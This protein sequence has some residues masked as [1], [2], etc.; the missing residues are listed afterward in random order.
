[1]HKNLR[2][3]TLEE[4][5][6]LTAHLSM[7]DILQQYELKIAGLIVLERFK[8]E[9][10]DALREHSVDYYVPP[11]FFVPKFQSISSEEEKALL[12]E[13]IYALGD[14][15][16]IQ[17]YYDENDKR[18]E[19]RREPCMILIRETGI[20]ETPGDLETKMLVFDPADR[21]GSFERIYSEL[22]RLNADGHALVVQ[23]G[24]GFYEEVNTK[25]YEVRIAEIPISLDD[26]DLKRIL[27][28]IL[29]YGT[30]VFDAKIHHV[31][32]CQLNEFQIDL[33]HGFLDKAGYTLE[34]LEK[35]RAKFESSLPAFRQYL[36]KVISDALPEA[37]EDYNQHSDM[38]R[39]DTRFVREYLPFKEIYKDLELHINHKYKKMD[40]RPVIGARNVSMVARSHDHFQYGNGSV[41]ICGGLAT[42]LVRDNQGNIV[43]LYF[44]KQSDGDHNY[45]RPDFNPTYR[46]SSCAAVYTAK[47]D[48]NEIDLFDL[49]TGRVIRISSENILHSE[50]Y[51][52]TWPVPAGTWRNIHKITQL[53]LELSRRLGVCV[54]LEAGSEQSDFQFNNLE[55]RKRYEANK[56][57]FVH[58]FN[59]LAVFQLTTSSIPVDVIDNVADVEDARIIKKS[60]YFFG[61]IFHEG[62]VIIYTGRDKDVPLRL[63]SE[64]RQRGEMP[65]IFDYGAVPY[66]DISALGIDRRLQF[67]N[68]TGNGNH[69]H[70]GFLAGWVTEVYEKYKTRLCIVRGELDLDA[71]LAHPLA[72]DHIKLRDEEK[73]L[74]ILK[75]MGVEA[76][77]GQ[78]QMYFK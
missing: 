71:M 77:K 58:G 32:H 37:E 56:R 24:L 66:E 59:R 34:E 3:P 17:P 23:G 61:S 13:K 45:A 44:T 51:N 26:V 30:A 73:G 62:D 25:D 18:V 27:K 16:C 6:S 74:L 8:D 46:G 50:H 75:N 69:H 28:D 47:F 35:D 76:A 40:E 70:N 41:D 5:V 55:K 15:T 20:D 11:L 54:E 65:L 63:L 4:L 12:R 39:R 72:K 57:S 60:N 68:Y 64:Y 38:L 10:R 19:E 33:S 31:G 49:R 48:Q 42:K 7:N 9:A 52:G 78:F 22:K 53:A 43:T 29:N 14:L 36:E 67:D 2:F 1:M 21:E